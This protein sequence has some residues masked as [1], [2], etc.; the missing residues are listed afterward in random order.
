MS[1]GNN[2]LLLSWC[3]HS[4]LADLIIN[5]RKLPKIMELNEDAN[6]AVILDIPINSACGLI[7][8]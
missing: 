3:R 6:G 7:S 1:I 2:R 4:E 8:R 5:R